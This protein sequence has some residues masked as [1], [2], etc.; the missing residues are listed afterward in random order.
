MSGRSVISGVAYCLLASWN[1]RKNVSLP[2]GRHPILISI[3]DFGPIRKTYSKLLALQVESVTLLCHR[4][5]LRFGRT[6]SSSRDTT[7]SAYDP[8]LAQSTYSSP[9]I[10][11]NNP[12]KIVATDQAAFHLFHQ[13][14]PQ[15]DVQGD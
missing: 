2:L 10:K 14:S 9:S 5:L 12:V 13:L 15:R 1:C 11:L 6:N 8:R 3:V 7:S 4:L